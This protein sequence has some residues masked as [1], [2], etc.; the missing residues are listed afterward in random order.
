MP[1]LAAWADG[2][3]GLRGGGRASRVGRGGRQRGVDCTS[4]EGEKEAARTEGGVWR[5]APCRGTWCLTFEVIIHSSSYITGVS[6]NKKSRLRST[7]SKKRASALLSF[8][9][10]RRAVTTQHLKAPAPPFPLPLCRHRKPRSCPGLVVDR[11]WERPLER[12]MIILVD[13]PF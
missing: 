11:G 9:A 3:K 8:R 5:R 4:G 1:G 6:M 12:G 7:W 10:S 13:T 2:G